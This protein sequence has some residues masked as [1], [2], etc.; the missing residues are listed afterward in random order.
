M[1]ALAGDGNLINVELVSKVVA[2]VDVCSELVYQY[3]IL[4]DWAKHASWCR[5]YAYVG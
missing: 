3:I 1:W 5:E 2:L 4:A